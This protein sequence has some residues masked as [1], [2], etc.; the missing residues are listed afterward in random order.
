METVSDIA[1]PIILLVGATNS[2]ISLGYLWLKLR[3]LDSHIEF[4]LALIGLQNLTLLVISI[5]AALVIPLNPSLDKDICAWVSR[6]IFIAFNGNLVLTSLISLT[7]YGKAIAHKEKI[8]NKVVNFMFV[9]LVMNISFIHVGYH[10]L[11]FSSLNQPFCAVDDDKMETFTDGTTVQ[12]I[13]MSYKY[14]WMIF[15]ALWEISMI[16][17]IKKSNKIRPRVPKNN[18]AREE[19]LIVPVSATIISH[20]ELLILLALPAVVAFVMYNNLNANKF[21]RNLLELFSSIGIACNLPSLLFFTVKDQR[22]MSQTQTPMEL[23][24]L[25]NAGRRRRGVPSGPKPQTPPVPKDLDNVRDEP[26]LRSKG[27]EDTLRTDQH[28]PNVHVALVHGPAPKT[29]LDLQ[30]QDLETIEEEDKSESEP[31]KIM[32]KKYV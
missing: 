8:S 32:E 1:L 30:I 12:F 7:R 23:D 15:W 5:I 11:F 28:Q 31:E 10:T 17:F 27:S 20:C 14:F 2:S 22:K 18:T 13:V 4:L 19:G 16:R 25:G 21:N 26:V 24:E 3:Q 6:P 29:G 9:K